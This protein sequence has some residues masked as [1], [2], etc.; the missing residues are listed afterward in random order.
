[1]RL[2]ISIVFVCAVIL[3]LS[4]QTTFYI[5]GSPD[6]RNTDAAYT[7]ATVYVN[8]S[9]KITNAT[10]IVRNKKIESVTTNGK[11]PTQ[12][13]EI[14]LSGKTIY[15][16]FVDLYSN[17]GVEQATVKNERSNREQFNSN[18]QGA[19]AWNEALKPEL[20][21]ASLFS[22]NEQTAN[23]Y[24]SAGFG[25]V[26]TANSDGI[27]RGVS[28]LVSTAKVQPHYSI[29]ASQVTSA[30]SFNKG[31]SK[32]NYPS[33][34]MGSIALIRQTY[35]DAQWYQQQSIEKNL[36]LQAFV[37]LAKL[38]AIFDAGNKQNVLRASAI[39]KEFGVNYIIKTNGDEYQRLKEIKETI[40][41]Y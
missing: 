10:I 7:H 41:V 40:S 34:L 8:A 39:A 33:S 12:L 13:K 35:L 20:D 28:A 6:E 23:F 29:L 36:S 27:C 17:Y 30:F 18:K 21:A 38:P 16:S 37:Q 25:V 3:R 14:N 9:T 2:G 26:L 1:M 5:N 24:K 11:V 32:Q 4:A 19:F 15:P 22:Y 31:S